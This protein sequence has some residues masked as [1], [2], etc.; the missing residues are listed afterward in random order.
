MD[1]AGPGRLAADE[2]AAQASAVKLGPMA[3]QVFARMARQAAQPQ[4][5]LWVSV[6]REAQPPEQQA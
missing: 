3:Q 1:A 4:E 6:A 5:A 2:W